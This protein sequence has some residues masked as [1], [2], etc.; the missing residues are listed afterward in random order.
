MNPKVYK[1]LFLSITV[2]AAKILIN[3]SFIEV[4]VKFQYI[5]SCRAFTIVAMVASEIRIG[6]FS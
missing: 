5:F 2:W 6:E 1:G 3:I 4:R